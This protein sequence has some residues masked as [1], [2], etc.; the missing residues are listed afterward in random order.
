MVHFSSDQ[1]FSGWRRTWAYREEEAPVPASLYGWTM[2]EGERRLR[3]KLKKHLIFRL[4]GLYGLRRK[5]FFTE[6][7][8][9]NRKGDIARVVD[10][11]IISPNWTPLVAEAIA[12]A[13]KQVLSSKR[14]PWGTYHVTGSGVTTP[15]EFA[16]LI[17]VKTNELYR[18]GFPM[19]APILARACQ[20]AARRPK[21]SVLNSAKFNDTFQYTLPD[22]RGQFLRFFGG[23]T[24]E[25][26]GQIDWI[27]PAGQHDPR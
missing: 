4:S 5:N 26:I 18:D 12:H 19:P 7:V 16:R 10:D 8:E 1:V 6:I 24:R 17:C 20:A 25:Q 22:W 9:R 2:L 15:Y 14:V 3:S 11:Q 27:R 23:L 13:I 21:F